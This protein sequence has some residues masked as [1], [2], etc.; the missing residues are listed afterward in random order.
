MVASG[1]ERNLQ[2]GTNL[3]DLKALSGDLSLTKSL[4]LTLHKLL[5]APTRLHRHH[6]CCGHARE[7]IWERSYLHRAHLGLGIDIGT[8]FQEQLH[9]VTVP[10][11]S[12]QVQSC[13]S[14]LEQ[15]RMR[16]AKKEARSSSVGKAKIKENRQASTPSSESTC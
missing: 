8:Y 9:A 1:V 11:L 4:K 10:T 5:T 16:E 12:S 7:S 14:F 13:E 15:G 6:R 3:W 2:S